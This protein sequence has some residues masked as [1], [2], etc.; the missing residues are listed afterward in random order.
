MSLRGTAIDNDSFVG[1]NDIGGNDDDPE[2]LLCH[3]NN[4]NCCRAAQG[5]HGDW[6]FPGGIRVGSFAENTAARRFN[7]IFTRSRDLSVV[8]LSRYGSPS[9]RG[10]FYC[11][12]INANNVNQTIYVNICE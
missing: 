12:I 1:L 10:R 11:E 3:T 4:T 8:R 9:Q 7:N 5:L 2:A 6:Y